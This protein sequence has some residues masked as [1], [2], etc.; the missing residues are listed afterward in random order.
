M[1]LLKFDQLSADE[2]S[3]ALA[4]AESFALKAL[5]IKLPHVEADKKLEE[6]KRILAEFE[7]QM[8]EN[9]F[10]K[11][12]DN[13]IFLAD[14]SRLQIVLDVVPEKESLT[15]SPVG[16]QHWFITLLAH[17]KHVGEFIAKHKQNT[18][19]EKLETWG[20]QLVQYADHLIANY[21]HIPSEDN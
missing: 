16:S 12:E 5:K 4:L 6:K 11:N 14:P 3:K 19:E 2:Q 8:R 10:V 21:Q 15:N 18:S 9:H 1:Q 20:N 17:V 7:K 13:I